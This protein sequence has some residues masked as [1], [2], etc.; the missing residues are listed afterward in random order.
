MIVSEINGLSMMLMCN[1]MNMSDIRM[2]MPY[3][4]KPDTY[5]LES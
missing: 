4:E 5:H 3:T 2:R 1:L